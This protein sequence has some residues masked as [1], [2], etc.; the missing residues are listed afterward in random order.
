MNND[1][2][3]LLDN[4]QKQLNEHSAWLVAEI[5]KLEPEQ[6]APHVRS[7]LIVQA[8]QIKLRMARADKDSVSV[9]WD[10][11]DELG[12]FLKADTT[13]EHLRA[14]LAGG[15]IVTPDEPATRVTA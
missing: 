11:P 3:I 7:V 13:P 14:S 6:T 8:T 9:V 15:H 4:A 10:Y 5:T 1:I 2:A 12:A